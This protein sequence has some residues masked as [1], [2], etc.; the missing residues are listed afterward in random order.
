MII[1]PD[2]NYN[3]PNN[4]K[5]ATYQ[6]LAKSRCPVLDSVLFD[7][8]EE[9]TKEKLLVIKEVLQSEYCTVRYQYIKPSINPVRGGNKTL[10]DID[11]LKNKKVDGTLMWL[12]Q[13]TERAKNTYGINLMIN[14]NNNSFIIEC[15]GKG[16]DISDIN[17]G[18][19]S[20]Q[21]TIYF[22]YPIEKGFQNE[23]WKY[24]KIDL[25]DQ[26]EFERDKKIRLNKLRNFGLNVNENIFDNKF[27]PL[28]YGLIEKLIKY[29]DRINSSW[30]KS[31]EYVVSLSMNNE[32]KLVFWDIQ[33]PEGKAKIL[34]K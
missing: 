33:T 1:L 30:N 4:E 32:G 25:V 17:R 11:E 29:V 31:D 23:W 20:P 8:N 5:I 12:L 22:K 15:V 16:F 3:F 14:R 10:I 28:D 2:Q 21:E 24:I 27:K 34:R 18:D 9:L 26:E 19:M 7:E 13:P 6:F